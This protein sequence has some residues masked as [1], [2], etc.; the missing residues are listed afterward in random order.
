MIYTG[1]FQDL[2]GQKFCRL[3]VIE[4]ANDY[5]YPSGRHRAQ[6]LCKC[7]C[8]NETIVKANDLKGGH[9]N[10]C[11]CLNKEKTKE[12]ST[13][14]RM[15]HSR[16]Y[17]AWSHMKQRCLD[18]NSNDYNDYGGRGIKV[19]N[20]WLE[21]EPFYK[22]ATENSYNDSLSIDR[23]DVDGNYEPSNCRWVDMKT[24]QNNRRN[25]HY[26]TYDGKTQTMKQW[27]EELNINYSTLRQRINDLG[28]SIDRAFNT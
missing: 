27:S 19:C 16:I 24:Q 28:W 15:S 10:S 21:F 17:N 8:G 13:K 6:W 22:W 23:I 11:G 9:T 1:K 7:D 3:T 14:H 4:R 26:I 18:K 20:E 5:V 25:N 12:R 2:T